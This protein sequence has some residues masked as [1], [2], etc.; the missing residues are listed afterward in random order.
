MR[1]DLLEL[2]PHARR[3]EAVGLKGGL[4]MVRDAPVSQAEFA[5]RLG[6][7]LR[8]LVAVAPGGVIVQRALQVRPLDQARERPLLGQRDLAHVLAH[9]RRD[10]VQAELLEDLLL[11]PALDQQL[12]VA[13]FLLRAEQAVFVQPQAAINRPLAHDDVVLLAAGE[14]HQRR[15]ILRVADHPQVGLD[16]ALQQHA[17]LG[18][19]LGQDLHNAGLAGEELDDLRRLLRRGEQVNVPNHLAM[20]PQAAR[21]AA[22]DRRPDAS[23]TLRAAAPPAGARR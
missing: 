6:N 11:G 19:A 7:L 22:A 2:L 14:I 17:G 23:A 4:R 20:P 9:L 8:A 3:V 18:L 1:G 12:R 16:A 21:R 13:R 15:G 10:I 5:H